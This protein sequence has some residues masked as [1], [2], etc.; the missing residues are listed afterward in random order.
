MLR[1]LHISDLAI[2]EDVQV[3]L[4][5]SLTVFTGATGAGK[6]LVVGALQ[7]LLGVRPAG[8]TVR[9]GAGE[10]RVSGVFIVPDQ[11]R[12]AELSALAD[13]AVDDEE[14][15]ITRRLSAGGRGSCAINGQPVTVAMLQQVGERLVDIHGQHDHQ[16][17]LKPGNQLG[18]LDAFA[19]CED[20]CDQL[21]TTY[22]DWQGHL[23]ERTRLAENAELRRQQ[24]E[25]YEFQAAEIDQAGVEP[26][27]LRA[28]EARHRRLANIDR[29][30]QAAG[31]AH[32]A[33]AEDD[34]LLDKL[35]SVV[36]DLS[37]LVELDASLGEVARPCESAA[38]GLDEAANDLRRYVEGLDFDPAEL[39]EVEARLVLLR[40]LCDK[41]GGSVEDLLAYRRKIE[42]ES[43]D[44]RRQQDDFMQID[45]LIAASRKR[46]DQLAGKIAAKRR[47][48]A[49]KLAARVNEQ[50]GELGMDK[51][52]F[53]LQLTACEPGPTGCDEAEMIVRTNPGQPLLPLRRVASGGELSRV[54]LAIKSVLA[55]TDRSSVLVFDEVDAHVGGRLGSVIGEKL[56]GLA[57]QHQVICITHLPQIAAYATRHL[58]VSKT[59]Q[60]GQTRTEVDLI[61]GQAR[62]DELAEMIAGPNKTPTSRRQ[63][64][65]LLK[66]AANL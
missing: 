12:R 3:E 49:K 2:I 27:E 61:E 60:R 52:T 38:L 57:G 20:V 7:L 5:E 40:R 29:I 58:K 51:A 32:A 23:A 34:G 36:R 37:D 15:L 8:Q 18:V 21:A 56:R 48:A 66:G 44:L 43:A 30:R 53:E 10:G 4:D 24:L 25:L 33:L 19:A 35:R 50:L 54:M 47:T 55:R 16:F 31:T 62:V 46:F 42:T 14:V 22:R 1:E 6:S 28:L 39:S 59:T 45:G 63:A 41:Y 65:E 13:I 26:G 17:L 64:R 11:R 9:A